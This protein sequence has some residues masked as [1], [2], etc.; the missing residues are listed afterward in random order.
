MV[1]NKKTVSTF[2]STFFAIIAV[3][4][5]ALSVFL[6]VTLN[7][8]ITTMRATIIT[9]DNYYKISLENS[10]SDNLYSTIDTL[11]A[12]DTQIAKVCLT[13]DND[14]QHQLLCDLGVSTSTL[15]ASVAHLPLTDSDNKYMVEQFVN[16]MYMYSGQLCTHIAH[17][18]QL[19]QEHID[20]LTQMRT[21]LG[22]M[23]DQLNTMVLDAEQLPITNSLRSDGSNIIDD[24][25]L[26]MDSNLMS[27]VKVDMFDKAS[28]I[29][30]GEHIDQQQAVLM[31]SD[32]LEQYHGISVDDITVINADNDSSAYYFIQCTSDNTN[33]Y[34]ILAKDG[35]LAQ[36]DINGT[37]VGQPVEDAATIAEQYCSNMGYDV[38]AIGMPRI[39]G[40][41][42]YIT[43]CPIIDGITIYPD[44]VHVA[45]DTGSSAV[46]GIDAMQ[47]LCNNTTRQLEWGSVNSQDVLDSI[48][49]DATVHSVGRALISHNGQELCCH[50]LAV[51][52]GQ[53]MYL[54]HVDSTSGQHVNLS[55]LN[56]NSAVIVR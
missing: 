14:M 27:R 43:L 20:T 46:V 40:N 29:E 24:V 35:R 45:V 33:A 30:L 21:A 17:G 44:M 19:T 47:Y 32:I 31:V 48:S 42:H 53:D 6:Y 2:W 5:I 10:M 15:S 3:C 56:S 12:V 9:D 23:Y 8:K 54:L 41:L 36:L 22:S 16:D 25:V 49:A 13:K 50:E 18:G 26:D 37:W 11:T 51:S 39:E 55:H 34:A 7:C 1:N 38:V 4:A 52:M 28:C